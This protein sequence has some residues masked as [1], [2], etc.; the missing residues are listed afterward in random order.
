VDLSM[1]ARR[2]HEFVILEP[3]GSL[4]LH[5]VGT[6]RDVLT[7]WLDAG[8]VHLVVDLD[9]VSFM[10]SSG[11]G[12]LVGGFKKARAHHGSLQLLCRSGSLPLVITVTGLDTVFRIHE[13]LD[14]L[15]N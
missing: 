1:S 10:D 8:Q 3:V 9:R 6:F 5:T 14:F 13:S 2:E 11:L 12:V 7:Q 15:T 4:D